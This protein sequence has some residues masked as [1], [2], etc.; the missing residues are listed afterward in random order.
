MNGL[1][2]V[3]IGLYMAGMIGLSAWLGRRTRDGRDYYVAG[4][5]MPWYAPGLS[6]MAT[7]CS[8][9]SLLGAPA[10]V[11]VHGLIW[12]QYELAVPLA[13]VFL[14]W[15]MLPMFRV[16]RLVSVYEYIE[17][18]FGPAT[19]TLLSVIFQ[20][21]R[22]FGTGIT[23]YGIALVMQLAIGIPFAMAVVLLAVITIV[24]DMLGGIRAVI[25]SDVIQM[26]VLVLGIV[27][28]GAALIGQ[29]GGWAEVLARAPPETFRTLDFASHG[30]GD[31]NAF[32]FW[33]MLFGGFFLY[34][35][36]YGCDQTQV[37]RE[38]SVRRI[39]DI[40][41]SLFLNGVGRFPLVLAYC[42][43][44]VGLAAYLQLNPDFWNA[45]PLRGDG[46]PNANVL[47]IAFVLQHLP[48]GIIGLF[49]IALFAA[50]M[51]SLDSTIN[52]L[53]A[54][55]AR[56]IIDRYCLAPGRETPLWG[57]R[58]LTLFWGVVC[59]GFAFAA[60]RIAGTIIEAVN[61]ISS[62][63]NGPILATFLLAM[64]TRRTRNRPMAAGIVAGFAGNFIVWKWLP[65]IS[66][67]WWN[68]IGA[69]V[70]AAV[71]Y[72]GSLLVPGP[73]FEDKRGLVWRPGRVVG[74]PGDTVRWPRVYLFLAV[75][76]VVLLIVLLA[77]GRLANR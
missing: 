24:Y 75:Y 36:Y 1:D 28:A 66:W 40:R 74:D 38:L 34:L 29:L 46:T 20:L 60:E 62:L 73:L 39:A 70:T 23:V 72:G 71:A 42:A 45:V 3:V 13:M 53:S 55:T 51:S 27:F 15:V 22:A 43:L 64:F 12:L 61:K 54:T 56:D 4:N 31:G 5:S 19:R 63:M 6:T 68:V 65:G 16:L 49:V 50:A 9:N 67:I 18:R 69:L 76:A 77:I 7:Q 35:A 58:L 17:M 44:G 11:V 59:T 21:T 47:L 52:S 25:W 2:W 8:T 14:M 57:N 48:N 32:A 33:P 26:G 10:F 41:W 30:L 37:Q